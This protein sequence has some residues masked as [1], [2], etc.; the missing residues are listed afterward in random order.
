M[1]LLRERRHRVLQ[2]R[3]RRAVR[4]VDGGANPWDIALQHDGVTYDRDLTYTVAFD[5]HATAAVTVQIQ[6]GP[7][8][9]AAFGHPVVLDGTATP[10]H[11]EFTFSP[12][13]WP[14]APGEPGSPVGDDWTTATG[15]TSFQLGGQAAAYTF[16]VDNFSLTSVRHA[17]PARRAQSS[18]TTSRT[19]TWA[20]STSTTRPAAARREQARTA[21]A[22]AST[23][24]AGTRTRTRPAWS[25]RTSTSSRAPTTSS[26][27]P[28][29]PAARRT[30][31]CSSGSTASRGTGCST[32]RPP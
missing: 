22:P 13:D 23:S 8:Y 20:A 30:S 27:S 31:T 21:S 29:T 25:T 10:Q 28:R 16:C 11:V 18:T 14:T 4:A 12:A 15:P 19:A 3:H 9:P 2:R 6:G 24:R 1:V 32:P 7:A 5:A 26:R 17:A